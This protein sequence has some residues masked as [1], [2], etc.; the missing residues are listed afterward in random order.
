[1]A[2]GHPQ[3]YLAHLA[4]SHNAAQP[5]HGTHPIL[6][7]LFCPPGH[8]VLGAM[9]EQQCRRGHH[10][11]L[12]LLSSQHGC[13]V[14]AGLGSPGPSSQAQSFSRPW[15]T[16]LHT[17]TP[18]HQHYKQTHIH[19]HSQLRSASTTTRNI[20]LADSHVKPDPYLSPLYLTTS[21]YILLTVSK[22]PHTQVGATTPTRAAS[23]A[24]LLTS[25]NTHV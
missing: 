2:L 16:H 12:A 19:I 3:R 7:L 13:Q 15:H 24:H 17:H 6:F 9:T 22:R 23:P 4:S 8:S 14:T 21:Q 11:S 5:V 25:F 1:M 10:T 20:C 18:P